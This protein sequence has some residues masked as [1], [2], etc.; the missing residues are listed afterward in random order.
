MSVRSG[1]SV[2][3]LTG[4]SLAFLSVTKEKNVTISLYNGGAYL[5]ILVFL[6]IF[7]SWNLKLFY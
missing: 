2:E 7:M 1:F 3:L 5:F 6:S 4:V